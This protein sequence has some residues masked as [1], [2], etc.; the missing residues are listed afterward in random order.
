MATTETPYRVLS[1]PGE[2][3]E[4]GDDKTFI[5]LDSA[6]DIGAF[7]VGAAYQRKAGETV[8]SAHHEAGPGGARHEELYVVVHGS[9]VFTVEGEEIAAPQGTAVFVH[10]PEAMREA[11][12]TEDETVVLAIGGP[13]GEAYRITPARSQEGF[14]E[15][16]R[17][18]DYAAALEATRRGLEIYP[19]NANLLYN[20][21]CMEAL[22]DNHGDALT[23]LAESVAQWEP[24]KE[25]ARKDDDFASLREDPRFVELVGAA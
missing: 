4:A 3:R 25:Q 21:A 16:Y 22:L 12:A 19:G 18:G 13:R 11:V 6:L 17:A 8:V 24:Y 9:A 15:A 7:G 2:A 10:E 20:V 5:R 1:L 23:A 14:W